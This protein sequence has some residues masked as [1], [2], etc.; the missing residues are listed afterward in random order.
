MNPITFEQVVAGISF[1]GLVVTLVSNL[2]TM[3][4]TA[5]KSAQEDTARLVRI[6]EGV[7]S[8]RS[9]VQDTQSALSTY[10]ARTDET[11]AG[12]KETLSLHD[13]RIVR[14]EDNTRAN[15]GRLTRLEAS[16]DKN[17]H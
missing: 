11:I 7:K 15:A 3:N 13:A 14:V 5:K 2:K 16:H 9:D 8:I 4:A 6:E 1:A 10:M 17:H 12:I